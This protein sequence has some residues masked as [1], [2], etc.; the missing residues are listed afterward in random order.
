MANNTILIV[1]DNEETCNL[2]KTIL[3]LNNYVCDIRYNGKECIEYLKNKIPSLI[4]LDL[5]MPVMDGFEVLKLIK[6]N[7]YYN[8]IPVI[9]ITAKNDEISVKDIFENGATDYIEKPFRNFELLAR[10]KSA[11][12]KSILNE[13]QKDKN[14]SISNDND[15]IKIK[16]IY[17]LKD[18][19]ITCIVHDLK[20]PLTSIRALTELLLTNDKI[21][22][23][24][25]TEFLKNILKQADNLIEMINEIGNFVKNN[26][27]EIKLNITS[28]TLEEIIDFLNSNF[29]HIAE[30]KNI[31]FE[32]VNKS[33]V[34][35]IN[36]DPVRFKELL[37]NLVSNSLKF[38]LKGTISIIISNNGKNIF[39]EIID[40]GIGIQ[41]QELSKI[42]E[43]FYRSKNSENKEGW[44]LGL[45][46]AIKIAYAHGGDIV[47]SSENNK[48][49]T[50]KVIIPL[51]SVSN[52]LEL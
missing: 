15:L 23:E 6:R 12:N 7:G 29:L 43:K 22:Q 25:I 44:G 3:E 38:T 8:N 4:L 39:F 31:N 27:E 51:K 16:N 26:A 49:S 40:T 41:E 2:I 48:G 45:Y 34:E 24:K 20:T 33:N 52:K 50:F 9:V 36:C 30:S 46:I 5:M 35:K 14:I 47:V 19:F 11:I 17:K 13:K 28:I 21:P 18:S 32:V 1:D 42:F 10:V 37:S